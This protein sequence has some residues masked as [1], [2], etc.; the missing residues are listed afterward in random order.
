M[1]NPQSK[2]AFREIRAVF[3]DEGTTVYQAFNAEIAKAAVETQKLDASPL[4]RTRMSWIKP[5]WCWIL[6]VVPP[7]PKVRRFVHLRAREWNR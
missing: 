4:Y 6:Y 1:S 7:S 2:P 5:S 3:D